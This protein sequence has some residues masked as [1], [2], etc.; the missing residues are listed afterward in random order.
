[1][2]LLT[3][4]G[5][6]ARSRCPLFSCLK[7]SHWCYLYPHPDVDLHANDHADGHAN[8]IAHGDAPSGSSPISWTQLVDKS[9]GSAWLTICCMG[10]VD[11]SL[12]KVSPLAI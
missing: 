11:R 2:W 4:L 3:W 10:Y 8:S 5:L 9:T 1:M 12:D 7:C 6:F